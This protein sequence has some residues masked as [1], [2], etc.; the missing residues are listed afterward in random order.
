MMSLIT[1]QL[2]TTSEKPAIDAKDVNKKEK[3]IH[4]H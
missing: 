4:D 3:N 2:R 1:S